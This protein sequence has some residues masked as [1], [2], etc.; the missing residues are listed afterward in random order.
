MSF[1]QNQ[2][3]TSYEEQKQQSVHV[4]TWAATV[5]FPHSG[6]YKKCSRLDGGRAE[7]EGLEQVIFS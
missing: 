7:D 2:L 5:Y 4:S 3:T 6:S 1:L